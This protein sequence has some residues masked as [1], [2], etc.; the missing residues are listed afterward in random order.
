MHRV[1]VDLLG[2]L[3]DPSAIAVAADACI[4]TRLIHMFT[5]L[6]VPKRV[7]QKDTAAWR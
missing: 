6:E 7:T 2:D 1:K 5:M 3:D 4:R